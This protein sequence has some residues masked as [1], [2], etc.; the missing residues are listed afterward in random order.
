MCHTAKLSKNHFILTSFLGPCNTGQNQF[1]NGKVHCFKIATVCN[2]HL[3]YENL[4]QIFRCMTQQCNY[5]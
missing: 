4:L 1:C 3:E 2:L 5:I